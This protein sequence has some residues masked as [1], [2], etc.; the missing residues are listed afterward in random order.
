MPRLS[1]FTL[2]PACPMSTYSSAM[3]RAAPSPRSR[4]TGSRSSGD[5]A[6]Y[7]V[8]GHTLILD[9]GGP[10]LAVSFI[11]RQGRARVPPRP[12]RRPSRSPGTAPTR[13]RRRS[14]TP[15]PTSGAWDDGEITVQ[16]SGDALVVET[17][18]MRLVAQRAPCRLRF[19]T[20]DGRAFSPGHVGRRMGR[21]RRPD[22]GPLL[23]SP[24]P[25]GALFSGS[26]TRRSG[27]TAA[28]RDADLLELGHLRLRPRAGPRSTSR[29]RSRSRSPPSAADGG[30]PAW[31]GGGP[32]RRQHLRGLRWTSARPK[33]HG[34][35]LRQ[36]RRRAALLRLRA[37]AGRRAD[38]KAPLRAYC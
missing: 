24:R 17:G 19:E 13:T 4:T 15:S 23:E 2:P 22:R 36:R 8:R 16:E 18:A 12:D 35:G 11:A 29:S 20:L 32:L 26:A 1:A 10:R 25:R 9:C 28:G 27:S 37:R 30:D 31:T 14:P 7:K 6:S 38:L 21:R 3:P 33:G 34:L 5:L